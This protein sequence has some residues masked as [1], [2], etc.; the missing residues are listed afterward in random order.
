M[1]VLI[2][3]ALPYLNAFSSNVRIRTQH[4]SHSNARPHAIYK[5]SFPAPSVRMYC[6]QP[7]PEQCHHNNNT[8]SHL[9]FFTRV[10]ADSNTL[11]R[12]PGPG[13]S[14]YR[15][16][17]DSYL[18]YLYVIK[19]S[20][21]LN[22]QFAD[23]MDIRKVKLKTGLYL[24]I[25]NFQNKKDPSSKGQSLSQGNDQVETIIYWKSPVVAMERQACGLKQ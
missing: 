19:I 23:G 12:A 14:N 20:T 6:M 3:T 2:G 5:T 8:I 7:R 25:Y 21:N 16:I 4:Y 22:R 15:R 11:C 24:Y 18:N 10:I 13:T 1:K 17:S 9:Y